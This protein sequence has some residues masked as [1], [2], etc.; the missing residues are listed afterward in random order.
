[1][2]TSI[3]FKNLNLFYSSQAFRETSIKSYI[4]NLLKLKTTKELHDIHALKDINFTAQKGDKIALF[5]H[6][7]AGKSTFLKTIAGIYPVKGERKV[8]GKISSL[9]E[10]NLGFEPEVSGRKNIM[11]R[12]LLF[13][14]SP[15]KVKGMEDEIVDFAELGEYIDY[16][17]KTYS[18]GMQIRLAFAI[19]TIQAGNILLLDEIIAAG[20][21]SF[22]AKAKARMKNLINKSDILVF[23][24]HDIATAL[25]VCNRALVFDHGKIIFDGSVEEAAQ[26]HQKKMS[27]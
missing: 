2:L 7:G 4:F 1:M 23:A 16:P 12:S 17:L 10:L 8:I 27:T 6:N 20:D 3:T 11:F 14:L 25:E 5:G 9:F 13:G 21:Q 22:V 26:M 19:S 18:A 24:T 15:K